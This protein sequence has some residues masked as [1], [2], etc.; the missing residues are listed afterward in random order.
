M[1]DE[2]EECGGRPVIGKECQVCGHYHSTTFSDWLDHR[3][4]LIN[5]RGYSTE[6]DR[7]GIEGYHILDFDEFEYEEE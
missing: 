1:V 4:E 2:C 3:I 7:L 5:Q 6:D